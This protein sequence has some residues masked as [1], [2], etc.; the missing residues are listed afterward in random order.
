MALKNL[1]RYKVINNQKTYFVLVNSRHFVRNLMLQSTQ[2]VFFNHSSI[3]T[4][5][6]SSEVSKLIVRPMIKDSA[7]DEQVY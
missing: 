1:P 3:L 4:E 7:Y 5:I 2:S 6:H